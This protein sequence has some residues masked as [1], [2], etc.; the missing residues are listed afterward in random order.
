M[1]FVDF[2]YTFFSYT[3]RAIESQC[4]VVAAAQFGRHNE[5][6]ESYGHSLVVDPWGEVLADAGGADSADCSPPPSIIT[7]DIDLTKISSVRERMPVQM[8][9]ANA[10]DLSKTTVR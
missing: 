2:S 4:Y 6:R 9:R 3:A 8:H 7:A 10:V 5:K 1:A